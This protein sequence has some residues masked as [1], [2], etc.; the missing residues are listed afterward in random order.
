MKVRTHEKINHK[1][2]AK[3]LPNSSQLLM[4]NKLTVNDPSMYNTKA[5]SSPAKTIQAKIILIAFM[6]S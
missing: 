2:P 6:T 5:T 1:K 4:S 3:N